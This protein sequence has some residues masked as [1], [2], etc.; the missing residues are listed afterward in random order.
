MAIISANR[1]RRQAATVIEREPSEFDGYW[2]N[3]GRECQN[4]ETG[5]TFFARISQGVPVASLQATTI[6]ARTSPEFAAQAKIGNSIMKAIQNACK[7]MNE[8]DFLNLGNLQIVLY[9]A[10]EVL[11][12]DSDDITFDIFG[13]TKENNL[14]EL[15]KQVPPFDAD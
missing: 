1:N 12:D 4:P 6:T 3:I 11:V 2:L 15:K 13:K 14:D 7:A 8:G 5:E 10:G 9:R